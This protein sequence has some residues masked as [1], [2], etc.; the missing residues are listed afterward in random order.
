MLVSENREATR[1][2]AAEL[3]GELSRSRQTGAALHELANSRWGL[4][5]ET[6]MAAADRREA[7]RAAP[8]CGAAGRCDRM[9]MRLDIVTNDAG[10]GVRREHARELGAGVVIAIY[11]LAKLAQM[12]DLDEPGVHAS[13]RADAPDHRRLLPA[14]GLERQ[15]ACSPHKAIFVAGQLL[16]GSRSTYEA[17]TELGELFER[18]GGSE[19][20]IQ[21]DVTREELLAFAEQIS[22]SYRAGAGTFRSPT[23]KI[24]LRA[25]ADAARL[26]GLELEDLSPDQRIVRMYASAVVIMRRFFEDLQ[27]SRYILPRRIKRIAQSLVD[28]SDGSTPSFLGVTEVRNANFDEAGRAVNTAI[29]AVSMAREV[30]QDR[31]ILSQI[32]MAGDDARRRAPARDGALAGGGPGDAWNGGTDDALGGSGGSPRGRRRRRAHGAR[33]RQRA[34]DHA[35][36]P[37]VRGALA[38][39]PDVARPGLLGSARADAAREAHRDRASLQRSPHARARPP[40]ADARLRRRGALGGAEGSAGPH[41]AAHARLGARPLADG[42][43]RAARDRRGR[44]GRSRSEGP[45]REARACAS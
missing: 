23:P 5:E 7:H 6:R 10:E 45:R 13:A 33:S 34:V 27:A 24:R 11:R 40:A 22:I 14:L 31:A 9:T 19:L 2:L 17:A 15:R 18:L 37:H 32:A 38:P 30:T 35:H 1:A 26:R 42:H 12:H 44:R 36:G 43:R 20:Y 25:V 41:R 4:S 16:K 29:L 21:R 39:P 3:L 28:L 8:R